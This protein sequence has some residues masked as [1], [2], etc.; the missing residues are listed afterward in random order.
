MILNAAWH[1]AGPFSSN[2][3]IMQ[4]IQRKTVAGL[5]SAVIT[6][7]IASC[8]NQ[9]NKDAGLDGIDFPMMQQAGLQSGAADGSYRTSIGDTVE[10]FVL[11][12]SSFNGRY[13]IRPSGDIIIPK[14]GRVT[15]AGLGLKELEGSVQQ[16]LQAT[17]LKKATVIADPVSR[18]GGT[19]SAVQAGVTVYISG[20]VAK[21]GRQFV[22]SV[23]GNAVTAFQAVINSGGF[24]SFAN[25]KKSFLLRRQGYGGSQRIVLNFSAIEEGKAEDIP[26]Q[27]GDMIVVPQKMFGL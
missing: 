8:A 18:S 15:A 19:E 4:F 24:T 3:Q 12:D 25:K 14:L 21:T 9:G 17:Q 26:L 2:N 10:I 5:I 27:E 20:S 6:T 11:E 13:V 22:P 1:T 16:Q 23:A 7:F